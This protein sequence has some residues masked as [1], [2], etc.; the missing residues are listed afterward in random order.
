MHLRGYADILKYGPKSGALF[1]PGSLELSDAGLPLFHM[2][3]SGTVYLVLAITIV[4]VYEMSFSLASI[5]PAC[6]NE[7]KNDGNSNAKVLVT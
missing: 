5:I 6:K 4:T 2:F 3:V 1:L 7:V